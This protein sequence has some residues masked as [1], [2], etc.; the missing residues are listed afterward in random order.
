M[1]AKVETMH[2]A[3]SSRD[4]LNADGWLGFQKLLDT[5]IRRT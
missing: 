4:P 5:N 2:E 3:L 1:D